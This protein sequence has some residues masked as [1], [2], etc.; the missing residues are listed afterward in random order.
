MIP[1]IYLVVVPLLCGGL[2]VIFRQARIRQSISLVAGVFMLV[3]SA[4]LLCQTL[5][6]EIVVYRLGGWRAPTGIVLAVDNLSSTVS[7]L[8]SLLGL[9]A[10]AYSISYTRE[11]TGRVQY[12]SLLMFLLAGMQ[13]VVLTG[14]LFNMFVFFEIL[15][16]SSYALVGFLRGSTELRAS[17]KYA[18]LSMVGMSFFL[19]GIGI[20]YEFTGNLN[21]AYIAQGL[22]AMAPI[23]PRTLPI[24]GFISLAVGL[25][26]GSSIV[27]L[28]TWLPDAHPAAPSPISALL[29]GVVV[30]VAFYAILR[31]GCTVFGLDYISLLKPTLLALGMLTMV[32]GAMLALIQTDL[33]RFLAY[34]TVGSMG[35]LVVGLG[36]GEL[37]LQGSIFHLLNHALAKAM[38]FFIAGCLI[39]RVG[40]RDMRR[41]G[42]LLNVA[43]AEAATFLLGGLAVTGVPP[44]NGFFSKLL[45]YEALYQNGQ[46]VPLVVSIGTSI[47]FLAIYLRVFQLV[48]LGKGRGPSG[49]MRMPGTM[50]GP[51]LL[52]SAL[53]LLIGLYPQP[54]LDL[55]SRI[56][57]QLLNPSEYITEVMR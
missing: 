23:A 50:L 35:Y 53:I 16:I 47:F 36:A 41:M 43:P 46:W 42:G 29:S 17:F 4:L 44:C 3:S 22:K 56:S 30:K 37:G 21:L 27:P 6:G 54:L 28:H 5:S 34:S 15:F 8:V 9:L 19:L 1:P 40:T 26:V 14:D 48:F 7:L 20:L 33:K 38:L 18:I 10:I 31:V 13:G 12:D 45:I 24:F 55:T 11:F 2:N 39:H 25:G 51:V 52:L 32:V 49:N 57:H